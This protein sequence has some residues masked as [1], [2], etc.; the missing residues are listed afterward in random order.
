MDKKEKELVLGKIVEKADAEWSKYGVKFRDKN[1]KTKT[2]IFRNQLT[3][4]LI[5]KLGLC[6]YAGIFLNARIKAIDVLFLLRNNGLDTFN[7]GSKL[8]LSF[9]EDDKLK[10]LYK[11]LHTDWEETNKWARECIITEAREEGKGDPI[12]EE[13]W[14]REA[15]GRY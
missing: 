3:D 11:E 15:E 8:D 6:H 12:T 13:E 5:K 14:Q 7:D 1:N 10:G 4:Y 2:E 9:Y